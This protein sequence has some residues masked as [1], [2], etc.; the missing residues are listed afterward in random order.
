MI[1]D[2]DSPTY[3]ISPT[4]ISN[5]IGPATKAVVPVHLHGYASDMDRITKIC[6]SQD[7]KKD[8]SP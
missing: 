5:A 4:A 6:S 8:P 1:V 3:C 2:V 7:L